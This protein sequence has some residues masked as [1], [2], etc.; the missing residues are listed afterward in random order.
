MVGLVR[1]LSLYISLP[2]PSFLLELIPDLSFFLFILS[3]RS[4]CQPTNSP[5]KTMLPSTLPPPPPPLAPPLP[6]DPPIASSLL[7][8]LEEEII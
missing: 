7:V 8:C 4:I 5:S 2:S 1:F 3:R 6:P